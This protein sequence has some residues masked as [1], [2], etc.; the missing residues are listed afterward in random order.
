MRAGAASPPL[1]GAA[2]STVTR[3]PRRVSLEASDIPSS[4]PPTMPMLLMRC[5][6]HGGSR[7][8]I[9]RLKAGGDEVRQEP[10]V[11]G[12]GSEYF[13]LGLTEHS[14]FQCRRVF[15]D[16]AAGQVEGAEHLGNTE[17]AAAHHRN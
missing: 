4:P 8:T 15:H 1:R 17:E 11:A 6:S 9:P 7:L 14:C 12:D 13:H 3:C 5:A 10:E 2:S 16:A